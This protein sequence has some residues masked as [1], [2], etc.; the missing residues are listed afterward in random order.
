MPDI[1]DDPAI[2]RLTRGIQRRPRIVDE[3]HRAAGAAVGNDVTGPQQG[4]HV[5]DLRRRVRD[6]HHERQL[7]LAGRLERAVQGQQAGGPHGRARHPDL[8]ADHEVEVSGQRAAQ[9]IWVEVARLGELEFWCD[10]ADRRD[11]D[12]GL[13]ARPGALDHL[14]PEAAERQGAG[15]AGVHPG[16]DAAVVGNQV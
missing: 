15:R 11:I 14:P 4:Q 16:G 10:Q 8:D 2:E 5:A 3:L 1:E 7:M 9:Q 12:E 13:D 6:V